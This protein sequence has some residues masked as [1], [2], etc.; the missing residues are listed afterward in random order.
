LLERPGFFFTA[1]LE[2]AVFGAAESTRRIS[3]SANLA[4]EGLTPTAR[5]ISLAVALVKRILP[6]RRGYTRFWLT[7]AAG[8]V[9]LDI[10]GILLQFL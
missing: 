3:F 6:V 8:D 5:L 7:D 2:V 9:V 10:G 4:S 1:D